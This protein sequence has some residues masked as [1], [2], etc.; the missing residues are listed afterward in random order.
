MKRPKEVKGEDNGPL[1]FEHIKRVRMGD[2]V[3]TLE[4]KE[5]LEKEIQRNMQYEECVIERPSD[6]NAEVWEEV[7]EKD[8]TKVFLKHDWA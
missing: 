7:W 1:M 5:D 4:D 6:L 8:L 2:I 3:D